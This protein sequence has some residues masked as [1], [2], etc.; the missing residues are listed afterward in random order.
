MVLIL[1]GLDSEMGACA[2]KEQSLLLDL[3][4]AFDQIENSY[5]LNFFIKKTFFPSFMRNMF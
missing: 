3:R 5:K 2:R 1:D 4:K